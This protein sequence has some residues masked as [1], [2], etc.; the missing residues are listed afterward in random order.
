MSDALSSI[1]LV[2]HTGLPFLLRHHL[3]IIDRAD[4]G[5]DTT[6]FAVVVVRAISV[7]PLARD[8]TFRAGKGAKVTGSASHM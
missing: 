6:A 3:Y 1:D 5:T 7:F 2:R 8:T 4:T